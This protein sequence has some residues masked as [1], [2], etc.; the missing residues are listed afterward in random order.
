MCAHY[1]SYEWVISMNERVS[2]QGFAIYKKVNNP[3]FDKL[4]KKFALDLK[5][6]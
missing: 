3:Y 6:I 4:V 2:Y 5:P 1:A